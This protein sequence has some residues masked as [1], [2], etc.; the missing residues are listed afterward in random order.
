MPRPAKGSDRTKFSFS[1]CW[2]STDLGE[3]IQGFRWTLGRCEC[4]GRLMP[5]HQ[6][7]RHVMVS[8]GDDG[9][10]QGRADQPCLHGHSGSQ[11][12]IGEQLQECRGHGG[13]IAVRDD[14]PSV[15]TQKFDGVREGGSDD[16]LARRNSLDQYSR[17][18]LLGGLIGKQD[19][20]R[21]PNRDYER[22]DVEIPAVELNDIIQVEIVNPSDE[23]L[24]YASP[25]EAWTLGCVLPRMM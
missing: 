17:G 25:S 24:V 4:S 9:P 8:A 3:G 16:R 1:A 5:R 7:C 2:P 6:L 15:G 23:A 12:G 11:G 22:L 18:D 13:R 10:V 14:D 21:L 19:Q 20:I